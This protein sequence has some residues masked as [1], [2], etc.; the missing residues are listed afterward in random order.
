[1][2]QE[3]GEA[4]SRL[5]LYLPELRIHAAKVAAALRVHDPD[6][7]VT[8]AR[9]SSD[10]AATFAKYLIETVLRI[11]TLSHGL[12]VSSV[13]HA[14]SPRLSRSAALFLSQSGRS[15]DLLATAHEIGAAG[16]TRVALLNDLSAPLVQAV[17]W[18]LPVGAGPE[19][20]VGATK[21]VIATL[22]AIVSLV[23]EWADDAALRSALETLPETLEMAWD[24]DWSPAEAALLSAQ[25]VFVLGRGISL[26]V[27]QEAALKF[28]EIA[29]LH[30]EAFSTA[31]VSHGPMTL[32]G[33]GFPVFFFPARD[34]AADGVAGQIAAFGARGATT[35]VA[36]EGFGG[37]IVLPVPGG[38]Q[39][40]VAPIVA[41]QSFYRM[42]N[43]LAVER[44]L[45]PDSPRFLT[46]VTQTL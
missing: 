31:E 6:L 42:I 17:D 25:S 38:L 14:T 10:H 21:S 45:D 4:P 15:P 34:E 1:M 41:L 9:G 19:A 33:S 46:K 20:A 7:V 3:A 8:C 23:A 18:L 35:I 40:A 43:A 32:A 16:G 28:K 13:Y 11:P 39:P 12:S 24:I 29:G 2:L 22:A 36:G 37:D 30:A 5:K 26:G 44:G 27:A